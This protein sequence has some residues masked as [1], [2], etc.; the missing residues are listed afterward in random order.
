MLLRILEEQMLLRF[1]GKHMLLR[2]LEEQMLL[3]L[4]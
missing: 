3:R 2:I 1:S 4:F